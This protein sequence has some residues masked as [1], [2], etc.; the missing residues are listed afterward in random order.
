MTDD[1]RSSLELPNTFSQYYMHFN[2]DRRKKSLCV[3][4]PEGAG[5]E[6]NLSILKKEN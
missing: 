3:E 2:F 5:N 4:L 1:L 6:F